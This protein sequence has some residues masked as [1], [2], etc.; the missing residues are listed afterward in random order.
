M[1]FSKKV[2]KFTLYVGLN[3]KNT[4]TQKIGTAQAQETIG[5]IFQK[6]GINGATFIGANGLYTYENT[7]TMELENSFKIEVLFANHKQIK[8]SI[9]NIK[10]ELN[11]ESVAVA[12]ERIVSNLT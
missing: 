2:N 5:K 8:K 9:E 12:R 4:K 3:D 7:N 11:Q 1:I 6:Y 10:K